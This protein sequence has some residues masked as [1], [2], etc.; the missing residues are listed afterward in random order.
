MEKI[1]PALKFLAEKTVAIL[2]IMPV[3]SHILLNIACLMDMGKNP[4]PRLINYLSE[5]FP[6]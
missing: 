6:F 5:K 1:I 3:T 2:A 4:D